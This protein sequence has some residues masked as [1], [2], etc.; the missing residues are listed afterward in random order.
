MRDA[1]Q[2]P[3]AKKLIQKSAYKIGQQHSL[4]NAALNMTS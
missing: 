1:L 2:K 3:T 4:D